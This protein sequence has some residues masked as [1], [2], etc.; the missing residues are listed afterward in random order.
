MPLARVPFEK[1]QKILESMTEHKRLIIIVRALAREIERLDE[2]NARL[3]AAVTM[4]RRA[5]TCRTGP[6][7]V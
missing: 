2:D 3:R 1:A 7:A 5:L 4:Y 6:R